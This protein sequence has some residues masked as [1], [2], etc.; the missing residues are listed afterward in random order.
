MKLEYLQFLELETFTRLGGR[1]EADMARRIKRGRI[2]RSL[3]RQERLDPKPVTFN[4][5]WLVAFNDG[6]LDGI[7]PER[8][9]DVQAFLELRLRESGLDVNTPRERW[10]EALRAW[11]QAYGEAHDAT[12]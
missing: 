7:A 10:A 1:L 5:A 8:M 2:L 4:L 12:P 9:G 6:L 11:M 3:V